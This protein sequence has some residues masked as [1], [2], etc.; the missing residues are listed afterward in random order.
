M[1]WWA[2]LWGGV[3]YMTYSRVSS[4][5][6]AAQR[7]HKGSEKTA[8]MAPPRSKP[9][10]EISSGGKQ[11][12]KWHHQGQNRQTKYRRVAN[13]RQNGVLLLPPKV[14]RMAWL[15]SQNGVQSIFLG[16]TNLQYINDDLVCRPWCKSFSLSI[17][18]T[19]MPYRHECCYC[20]TFVVVNHQYWEY[21]QQGLV[22]LCANVLT[23]WDVFRNVSWFWC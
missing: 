16:K 6:V 18:S 8:K 22:L 3:V 4:L 23:F 13:K 15:T 11:A 17:L 9:P 1:A 19:E 7:V 5:W 10:D 20:P 2:P 21:V 14:H 12:P